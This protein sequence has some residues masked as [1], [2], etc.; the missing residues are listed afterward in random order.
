MSV[1]ILPFNPQCTTLAFDTFVQICLDEKKSHSLLSTTVVTSGLCHSTQLNQSQATKSFWSV[2]EHLSPTVGGMELIFSMSSP[3]PHHHV[4]A[5]SWAH[6]AASLLC[7]TNKHLSHGTGSAVLCCLNT[8]FRT[9]LDPKV[10]IVW[11]PLR[12]PLLIFL[13]R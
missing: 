13:S 5:I 4:T 11:H 9:S 1:S 12:L 2:S 7:P 3:W 8:H 6:F 10:A